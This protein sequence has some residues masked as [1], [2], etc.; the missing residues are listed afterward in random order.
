[1]RAPERLKTM[2]RPLLWTASDAW[3]SLR[4]ELVPPRRLRSQ[5][6]GD[7]RTVGAD[8][9]GYYETFGGLR[10]SDRVLD[11]GCGPGRMAIPLLGY[12]S[13]Q[14]SY[15]GVDTWVEAVEWCT[16]NVT[17]RRGDFRFTI[18]GAPTDSFPFE[19]DSFDFAVVCAISKLDATTYERY[20]AEAARLLRPGGTYF[21]TC[22]VVDGPQ[23]PHPV[24][25]TPRSL[26]EMLAA[27]EIRLEAIHSG[28]WTGAASP[29]SYQD[30][31]IGRKEGAASRSS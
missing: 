22:F 5:V 7:F 2:A 20:V 21:G 23:A 1:M 13:E 30:V 10:P 25:F 4:G 9:V 27:A 24:S 14:G 11:I 3:T 12:L 28:S 31:L 29:L 17:P 15:E 6:P 19:D 16:S 26:T 8:F 18:L